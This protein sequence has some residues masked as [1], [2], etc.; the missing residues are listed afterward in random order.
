MPACLPTSLLPGAH[1]SG[2]SS[3]LGHSHQKASGNPNVLL[4]K[5]KSTHP[6]PHRHQ[7]CPCNT[8]T[9]LGVYWVG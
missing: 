6:D 8:S 5:G 9:R 1:I 7:A 2:Y 4:D 3:V